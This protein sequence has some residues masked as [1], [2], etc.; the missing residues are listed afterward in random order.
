MV[1]EP[2]AAGQGDDLLGNWLLV[3]DDEPSIGSLIN[4]VAKSI[5]LEVV[6]TEDPAVFAKTARDW[7]PSIIILDL[8]LPGLDGIELLRGLAADNCLAHIVLTSAAD[9]RVLEAA[10]QLGRDRGLNMGAL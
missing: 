2:R 9:D 5:G 6:V 3:V 10:Q 7:H 8:K 4:K 1:D